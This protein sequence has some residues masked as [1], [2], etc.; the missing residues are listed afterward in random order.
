MKLTD[1]VSVSGKPGLFKL[2]N[3]TRTPLTVEDLT[4]GRKLPLFPRDNIAS[5]ADISIYTTEGDMPLGEVFE[6]IQE[7]YSD[8][9]PNEAEILSDDK[10]LKAIMEEVLPIYDSE[11]VHKSDIKKLVKWYNILK[12][13]GMTSFVE[14]VEKDTDE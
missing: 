4:S 7:K 14:E 2:I 6:K 13:S 3:R 11:R 12:S 10:K 8:T 9:I 5:L 1:V